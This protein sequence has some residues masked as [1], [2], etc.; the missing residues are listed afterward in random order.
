[1]GN[2]EAF[3]REGERDQRGRRRGKEGW[4]TQRMFDKASSNHYFILL[5]VYIIIY[6]V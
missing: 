1:M 3:T 2:K 6:N 5:K 4:T